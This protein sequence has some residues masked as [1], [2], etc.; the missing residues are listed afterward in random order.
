MPR[1]KIRS[2]KK[3]FRAQ[4]HV[5]RQHAEPHDRRATDLPLNAKI[6]VDVVQD[7]YDRQ[8][9]ITVA[10]SLRDDTLGAMYARK[11]IDGVQFDAGRRMQRYYELSEIGT[12]KAIDPTKER[13]DG[14][15]AVDV[16]TGLNQHAMKE[17]SRL[18]GVLGR[19]GAALVRDVL[20]LGFSLAKCAAARGLFSDRHIHFIGVRFRECL[21]TLS[22]EINSTTR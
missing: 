15:V 19:E 6:A 22:R 8:S 4:P 21:E 10:R 1:I 18:E 12:V 2:L 16:M 5:P 17:I 11:Q 7:P 20:C 9:Q 3:R 14:G 13:V